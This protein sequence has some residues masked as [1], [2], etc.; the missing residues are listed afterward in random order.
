MIDIHSHILPGLDDGAGSMEEAL[1]MARC[2]A[3]DGIRIMVATPHVITGL[4]AN[5][6]EV[7]LEAVEQIQ[8]VLEENEIPLTI[9]P[10][11]EYR[12]EPD[13]GRRMARGR[14]LTINDGGRY[15]LVEM[16]ATVVPDYAVQVFY[17]LQL[18]GV[19]PIIAHPER[20]TGFAG[21]PALLQDLITRG[22]LA[23]LT[24]GSLSGLLG[25]KAAATA[26]TFLKLGYAH[27]IASDAHNSRD[28][29]PLLAAATKEAV[30]LLGEEQGQS[31]VVRNPHRAVRGEYLDPGEIKEI[32]PARR[33]FFDFL[34]RIKLRP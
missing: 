15:L 9:L 18:Q 3:A 2:A 19:Q 11:A 25:S 34:K 24:A 28:R 21:T 30:R 23:Q 29:A 22:A 8:S 13:L 32:R 10:G 17:E 5:S 1:A 26:R 16:P 12:L 31:L 7:I 14:L 6:R 4:Y 33:S 20:N 27:F